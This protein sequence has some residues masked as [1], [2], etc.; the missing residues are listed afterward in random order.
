MADMPEDHGVA[1]WRRHH[2]GRSWCLA[3]TEPH[4]LGAPEASTAARLTVSLHRN[5]ARGGVA[6]I[7][8]AIADC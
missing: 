1:Q 6:D 5:A 3:G 4:A 2:R 8:S 7:A